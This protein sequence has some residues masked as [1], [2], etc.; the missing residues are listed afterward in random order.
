MAYTMADTSNTF[1]KKSNYKSTSALNLKSILERPRN[2]IPK[3]ILLAF[4]PRDAMLW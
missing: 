1:V 2:S 3:K 4:L